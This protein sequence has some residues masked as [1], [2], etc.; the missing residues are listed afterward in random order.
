MPGGWKDVLGWV[1]AAGGPVTA[2]EVATALQITRGA[3]RTVLERCRLSGTVRRLPEKRG[4]YVLYQVTD[5]V[6]AKTPKGFR[7]KKQD[8]NSRRRPK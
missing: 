8:K 1:Y 6:V 5:Q 3:S 7:F 4:R 2:Q